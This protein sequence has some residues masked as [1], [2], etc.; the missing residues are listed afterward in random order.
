MGNPTAGSKRHQWATNANASRK[1]NARLPVS[2]S[3][4]DD[5][6]PAFSAGVRQLFPDGPLEEALAAFAAVDAIVFA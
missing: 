3:F 5:A 6:V 1:F 2:L 4:V